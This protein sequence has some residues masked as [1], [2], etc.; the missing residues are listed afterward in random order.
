MRVLIRTASVAALTILLATPGPAT[1]DGVS[2]GLSV[3]VT[4]DGSR[5]VAGGDVRALYEIDPATLEVKRRVHLGRRVQELAF[6]KDGTVLVVESTEAMQWLDAKTLQPTRTETK[7][8]RMSVA[9]EADLVAVNS[10]RR[11]WSINVLQMKTGEVTASLPYESRRSIAG[12]G[13][14]PDGKRV[15]LLYARQKNEAEKAVPYKEIP[16]ELKGTARNEFQQKNDGYT[17]Q[18]VVFDVATGKTLV[19]KTLW[20]AP[21]G[22]NNRFV[23]TGEVLHVI[24]YDNQCARITL[25]GTIRYFELA[26]SYNYAFEASGDGE[27]LLSGGLRTGT[28][29]VLDGLK[30]TP[31]ELE[32]IDGFPEYF[33]DFSIAGD[34]TAYG[35]TTAWRLIKIS[36]E[37]KIVGRRPVY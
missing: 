22:G 12:F 18:L 1:A 6:S 34:G 21:K 5:I 19:D 20:Y 15:A 4:R 24:A 16:Q 10:R 13:I 35:G 33:K 28:R 2:N 27:V 7:I 29:T 25:D 8:G 17:S 37:G 26:N 3:A 9:A 30:P 14:T 31:F 23:W 11:P 32:K 36:P